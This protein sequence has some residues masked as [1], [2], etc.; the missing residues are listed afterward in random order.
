MVQ[1]QWC[2]VFPDDWDDFTDQISFQN[3]LKKLFFFDTR[4]SNV[5]DVPQGWDNFK[6]QIIL[7]CF[8]N[9]VFRSLIV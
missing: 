8:K 2:I 5:R 7:K 9:V 3:G 4:L 1:F 6:D